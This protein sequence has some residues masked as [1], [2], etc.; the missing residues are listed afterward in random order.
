MGFLFLAAKS[1]KIHP[2]RSHRSLGSPPGFIGGVRDSGDSGGLSGAL[3]RV[4]LSG[5]LDE[6][7]LGTPDYPENRED[8]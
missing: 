7:L 3:N 1:L 4:V 5:R 2:A 8:I 6:I